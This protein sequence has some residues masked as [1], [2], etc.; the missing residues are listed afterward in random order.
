MSVVP[1]IE[2]AVEEFAEARGLN[3]KEKKKLMKEVEERFERRQIQLGEAIGVITAQS[4][5]EPSTQ[6]TMRTYHYAGVLEMNVTLG[7]P[8]LIELVDARRTPKT[9]M[10]TVYL[11]GVTDQKEATRIASKIRQIS[12]SEIADEVSTDLAELKLTVKLD[13]SS[14]DEFDMDVDEVVKALRKSTR[15]IKVEPSGGLELEV[16]PKRD[17]G[18]S[19]LYKKKSKLMEAKVRGLKGI[20]HAIIKKEKGE[21]VIYTEGTALSKVLKVEGVD[22]TRTT[23][24]DIHEI[25][26]VLG[27]EAARNA[28]VEELRNT[29]EEAGVSN[30]DTRHLMLI[31]DVMTVDGKIKAIGRYGVAGEKGSVLARASF[32]TPMRHLLGASMSGEVD[33]LSS[34]VENVMIGQPVKVGTGLVKLLVK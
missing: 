5:G 22:A 20:T 25:E 32:E 29:L 23:S 34:V 18:L 8:R 9:P 17:H 33:D 10:M 16:E 2:S 12:L 14:L 15:G 3:D 31:S 19:Y 11:D 6:L 26:R 13:K 30:V 4:I 1:K 24:N 27:I 21:F 7:L 28:I